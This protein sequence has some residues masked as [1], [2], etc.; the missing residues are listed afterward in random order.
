MSASPFEPIPLFSVPLFATMVNGAEQHQSPLIQE[1][2]DHRQ[3]DPAGDVRSNR[4]G[5]HSSS[6]FQ[7]SRHPSIAWVLQSVTAFSRRALAPLYGGWSERELALG[8][9]WAN[10]LGRHGFNA[11]HHHLPQSW[12]GVYYVQVGTL[13]GGHDDFSGWIEFLN[14]N[15]QQSSW[16]SGNYLQCPKDGMMLLFPSSQVH[17]VHPVKVKSQRITVAFNFDV[18]DK[19]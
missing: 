6:S 12:S 3:R 8:S 17:Y 2:L 1:I 4:N 18:V 5:W 13:G 14:P 15:L 11:P 10:V 19:G 16:G 9:Y 7:Q